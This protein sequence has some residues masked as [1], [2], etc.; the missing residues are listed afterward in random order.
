[1]I[2]VVD[3]RLPKAL[4]GSNVIAKRYVYLSK[5]IQGIR[6]FTPEF[7]RSLDEFDRILGLARLLREQTHIVKRVFM[8]GHD[9]QDIGINAE[10]FVK[11]TKLVLLESVKN[12]AIQFISFPFVRGLRCHTSGILDELQDFF[13][14][15]GFDGKV[16]SV[17]SG[18][19]SMFSGGT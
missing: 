3:K 17:P 5:V 10:R 19:F 13:G 4:L 15:M 14:A 11:L 6:I 2:F 8:F 1:M 7:Q 16:H 18:I 9:A 12:L